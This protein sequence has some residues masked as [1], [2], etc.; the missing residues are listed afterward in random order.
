MESFD[1]QGHRGARGLKPE[2]TLPSFE[3]ALDAGVSSIETDLHLTA[4]H[5]PV[6]CHDRQ[7]HQ[8]F[9]RRYLSDG[10]PPFED[11]PL[12]STLTAE[13]LYCFTADVVQDPR[14]FPFQNADPTPVATL[15]AERRGLHPFFIPMLSD[16]FGF[17]ESYSGELGRRVGKS[18]EQRYRA[19]QVCFD[20]ELKHIP[21]FN[22]AIEDN[23]DGSPCSILEQ[24]LLEA[25]QAACV[26]KRVRIR[27]FD[28][29]SVLAFRRAAASIPA[30]VLIDGAAPVAPEEMARAALAD[31]YCP[32]YHF[33][34]E[35]L[36]RR[37]RAA[38][39]R[40]HPYTVNQEADWHRLIKWGVDGIT[41]DYPDQ[42]GQFL[43]KRNKS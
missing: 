42:L 25:I 20:L 31:T 32:N 12:L 29:R 37:L 19:E 18:D 3:A 15:Y 33:L 34:D 16:L 39:M 22:A 27:S 8:G 1:L 35:S 40:V 24:C 13:Q 5:C 41:T 43:R 10:S 26:S 11:G 28:H 4:D 2:N 9:C 21:Y 30:S 23:S 38:G 6:L 7:L 36:A 17:V 14:I